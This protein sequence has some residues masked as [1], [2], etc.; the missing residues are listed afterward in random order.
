MSPYSVVPVVGPLIVIA[1]AVVSG[2]G[3]LYVTVSESEPVLPAASCAVIV[4]TL[5]PT[6][7]PI[8][9]TLHVVVPVVDPLPPRLFDQLTDVTPTLS[10]AVPPSERL[11]VV[12]VNDVPLVGVAIETVGRVVSEVAPEVTDHVKVSGTDRSTPSDTLAVTE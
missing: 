8:E 6:C 4:M 11:V 3:A 1:G 10:A 5:L 7:R 9:G 2:A 12:D